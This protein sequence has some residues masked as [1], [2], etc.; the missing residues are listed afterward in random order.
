[1]CASQAVIFTHQYIVESINSYTLSS[2]YHSTPT[3]FPP[4]PSPP[5]PLPLSSSPSLSSTFQLPSVCLFPP[6]PFSI[7]LPPVLSSAH[8]AFYLLSLTI[9]LS[10]PPPHTHTHFQPLLSLCSHC[11]VSNGSVPSQQ[12]HQAEGRRAA[13]QPLALSRLT[14]SEV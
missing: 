13:S 14:A 7:S 10:I 6:S 4:L 3:V 9:S 2:L 1:M 8:L 5:P 12:I 11:S